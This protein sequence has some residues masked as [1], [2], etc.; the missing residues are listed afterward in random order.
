MYI[1]QSLKIARRV[2]P[3]HCECWFWNPLKNCY[4]SNSILLRIPFIFF[5]IYFDR[6]L[7]PFPPLVL[8]PAVASTCQEFVIKGFGLSDVF[9]CDKFPDSTDPAVCFDATQGKIKGIW[10]A[11][12]FARVNFNLVLLLLLF[13]VIIMLLFLALPVLYFFWN[14][15]CLQW[16]AFIS[17]I[18]LFYF[19]FSVSVLFFSFFFAVSLCWSAL[20]CFSIGQ[21]SV[22]LSFI[23][24]YPFFYGFTS[25]LGVL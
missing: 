10:S 20:L 11:K 17:F 15:L 2:I 7:S 12:L 5:F 9:N 16:L 23:I 25:L 6:H 14:N 13:F 4:K 8:L 18:V 19:F 3:F 1:L 24:Y 22:H 21:N